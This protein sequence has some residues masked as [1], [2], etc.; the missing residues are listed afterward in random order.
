MI[1]PAS[2]ARFPNAAAARRALEISSIVCV[3]LTCVVSLAV[4]IRVYRELKKEGD[5]KVRMLEEHEKE[6]DKRKK[7]LTTKIKQL[8]DSLKKQKEAEHVMNKDADEDTFHS[9]PLQESD[10][11]GDEEE[12]DDEEA[13]K[14]AAAPGTP[15]GK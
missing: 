1:S 15:Q 3:W 10:S 12:G 11:E 7:E 13:G 6:A 4:Q 8:K 2:G 5:Y 14:G 9:N